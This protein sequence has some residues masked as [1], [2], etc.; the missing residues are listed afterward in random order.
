MGTRTRCAIIR[1]QP[2]SFSLAALRQSKLIQYGRNRGN[3]RQKE[4]L[5]MFVA[6]RC[7]SPIKYE[8]SGTCAAI[9]IHFVWSVTLYHSINVL[10]Y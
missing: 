4:M 5:K 3:R 10:I 7:A 1:S 2:T 8:T 9:P 6:V